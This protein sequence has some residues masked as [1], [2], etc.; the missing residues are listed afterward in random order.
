[1]TRST[2]DITISGPQ[3]TYTVA[4]ASGLLTRATVDGLT[5]LSSGPQ[6]QATPL[7][8]GEPG[9][10]Q[11][12]QMETVHVDDAEAEKGLITLDVVGAYREASGTFRYRFRGDGQ[13]TVEYAFTWRKPSEPGPEAW[14]KPPA[15]G[16]MR[17]VGLSFLVPPAFQHLAWQ[18]SPLWTTYPED[19]LGRPVGRAKAFAAGG[20]SAISG[21]TDVRWPAHPWASD[22]SPFGSADFRSSKFFVRSA[23]LTNDRGIGVAVRPHGTTHVRCAWTSD[24]EPHGV[25]L[26]VNAFAN[27]GMEQF[28]QGK[29]IPLRESLTLVPGSE[30]SGA[31]VLRLKSP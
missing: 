13:W 19:H 31:V 24:K 22:E 10:C 16:E 14:W 21:Q 23:S 4:T 12:W 5:V 17:E 30:I 29:G 25:R 6:L 3:A 26:F 1:V 18:R 8:A 2:D 15:S 20:P 28:L 11:D 7:L 27:G 9:L